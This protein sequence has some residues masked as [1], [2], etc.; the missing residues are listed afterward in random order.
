MRPPDRSVLGDLGPGFAAQDGAL[1]DPDDLVAR[2]KLID[3]VGPAHE[4]P[5]QPLAP[6]KIHSYLGD[7]ADRHLAHA[8]DRRPDDHGVARGVEDSALDLLTAFQDE[9]IGADVDR[10]ARPGERQ[11]RKRWQP[12]AGTAHHPGRRRNR[13]D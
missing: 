3:A 9:G 5:G 10:C 11:D 4:L 13:R 8:T 1:A 7:V 2:A 12:E 6:G